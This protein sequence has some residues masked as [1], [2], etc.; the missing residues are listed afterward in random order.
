MKFDKIRGTCEVVY[1]LELQFGECNVVMGGNAIKGLCL[2]L[3]AVPMFL[4]QCD[5]I[6]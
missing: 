2:N 5:K 4:I 1:C 6:F 3:F